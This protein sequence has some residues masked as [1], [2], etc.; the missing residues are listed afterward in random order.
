MEIFALI[1]IFNI[2]AKNSILN[3]WDG[4]EYLSGF[5]HVRVLNIRKFS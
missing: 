4:S 3:L 1:V 2:L 5:K